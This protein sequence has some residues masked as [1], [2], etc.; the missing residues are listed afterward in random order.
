MQGQPEA[1][2][3]S[4]CADERQHQP[5]LELMDLLVVHHDVEAMLPDLAACLR[6]VVDFDELDLVL[7]RG[8]AAADLYTLPLLAAETRPPATRVEVATLPPLQETKLAELWAAVHPVVLHALDAT[9]DYAEALTGLRQSGKR[10]ACLLPLTTAVRPVGVL[11]LASS[12]V[13]AYDEAD[14][15]FLERVANYV[16]IAVDDVRRSEETLAQQRRLEAERDH[17]RTLLEINN[18]VVTNLDLKSLRAAIAPS[19]RR[20]VPH[21]STSLMLLRDEGERLGPLAFDPEFPPWVEEMASALTLTTRG[22][23][24]QAPI[25]V[26]LALRKPIDVD[27]ASSPALEPFVKRGGESLPSKRLCYVPLATARRRLGALMLGRH[28]P[29]PFTE[30]EMG[31]AMQ[32]ADQI[33]IAIENALAFG[34]ID[35]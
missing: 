8:G 7:P 24:D 2:T 20:I 12:N 16:A 6:K 13:G 23:P 14:Q 11:V 28:L 33:A 31:R 15:A 4:R 26:A 35:A 5:L 19:L 1:P 10:S 18:A 22:R 34:E 17:W 3:P 25:H 9:S 32:A 30:D 27:M 29:E 21:D